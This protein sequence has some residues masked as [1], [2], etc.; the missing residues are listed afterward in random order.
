MNKKIGIL[1]LALFLVVSSTYAIGG[2]G[3]MSLEKTIFYTWDDGNSSANTITYNIASAIPSINATGSATSK[4]FFVNGLDLNY[5]NYTAGAS[6][7][8]WLTT[9][10][11]GE[12]TN[13][14]TFSAWL[15]IYG[16]TGSSQALVYADGGGSNEYRIESNSTGTGWHFY[17]RT[18]SGVDDPCGANYAQIPYNTW[19]NVVGTRKTSQTVAFYVNG[20]LA[21][22]ATATA[23]T[24]GAYPDALIGRYATSDLFRFNGKIDNFFFMNASVNTTDV[25][26]LNGTNGGSRVYP[27]TSA[28]PPAVYTSLGFPQ[29]P[30]PS[31]NTQYN[32]TNITF[33]ILLNATYAN[34]NVSLWLDGSRVYSVIS[35]SGNNQNTTFNT[36][37]SSGQHT[38]YWNATNNE[39]SILSQ[40]NLFYVDIV[41]PSI[42]TSFV[43]NSV[44]FNRNITSSFNFTDDQTIF[45]YNI[46]INGNTIT[47]VFI[48]GTTNNA[49]T[50][51]NVNPLQY[52]VGTSYLTARVFDGHTANEL[53]DDYLISKGLLFDS[54]NINSK[55]KNIKISAKDKTL[56][57][58]WNTVRD[59]DRYRF[60]YDPGIEKSEKTFVLE[61]E[62]EL[63]ILE[64]ENTEYKKWAV[65]GNKW[66]D[67]KV[68]GE[69]I[70]PIVTRIN[71]NKVEF[72]LKGLKKVDLIEFESIGELNL[73]EVTYTFYT[74]NATANSYGE[75]AE[76]EYGNYYLNISVPGITSPNV[77]FYYNGQIKNTTLTSGTN[78]SYFNVTV[79]TPLVNGLSGTVPFSWNFSNGD[80]ISNT[81][82]ITSINITNCSSPITTANGNISLNFRIVEEGTTSPLILTNGTMLFR[83]W[84]GDNSSAKTFG[85]DVQ[86]FNSSNICIYTNRTIFAN[87]DINYEIG[88]GVQEYIKFGDSINKTLQTIYL[89]YISGA[90]SV[91]VNVVDYLNNALEG[92]LLTIFYYNPLTLQ[93]TQSGS[94]V[95]DFNGNTL[96]F[97][98]PTSTY[99][100]IVY[101]PNGTLQYDFGNIYFVN[102]PTQLKVPGSSSPL[103]PPNQSIIYTPPANAS[104]MNTTPENYSFYSVAQGQTSQM[105]VFFRFLIAMFVSLILGATFFRFVGSAGASAIAYLTFVGFAGVGFISWIFPIIAGMLI[106]L[107][108][109]AVGGNEGT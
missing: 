11:E 14:V 97:Y 106:I 94:K 92:H 7:E 95:I 8:G 60:S 85:F 53:K 58:D 10:D 1:I 105:H 4:R 109:I 39:T 19:T 21:C 76:T 43:N 6:T 24:T 38:F 49:S 73:R 45:S 40:T 34:N 98:N 31:N 18:A 41:F 35:P 77:S 51:L 29:L 74:F 37:V 42:S 80:V 103:S 91:V 78:M 54:L 36:L 2:S 48:N 81:Q 12:W 17:Y 84:A 33:D 89:N 100:P 50:T 62:E 79:V 32:T 104:F 55:G 13:E 3:N 15:Y 26:M 23:G 88:A 20:K 86:G 28:T 22:N 46:S 70:T 96:F 72:T 30:H 107:G 9:I 44:Y 5:S 83:V 64:N 61:C 87:Y 90:T 67:F 63:S 82:Y 65:C 75:L 56:S 99:R 108:Y 102:N 66:I 59:K 68:K 101:F 52:G 25:L 93:Y 57:D 16:T 47:N 71:N 27:F 69:D